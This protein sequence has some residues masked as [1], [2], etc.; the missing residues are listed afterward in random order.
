MSLEQNIKNWVLLDNKI[1]LINNEL[2]DLKL[3]KNKYNNS[4]IEYIS[5]NN[6]DNV[7]INISDG[8]L[9]FANTNY[10]QPLTYKH[11]Y[12][13]LNNYFND[14]KKANNI[15]EYIKSQRTSKSIKEIKRYS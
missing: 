9:K 12:N 7:T 4:I 1:K 6:L 14:E 10:S 11:I 8:K 13:C 2:R 15:I 3:E 5:N